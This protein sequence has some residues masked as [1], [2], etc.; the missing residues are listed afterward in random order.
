MATIH[1]VSSSSPDTSRRDKCIIK[2]ADIQLAV[3]T[4]IAELHSTKEED[5]KFAEICKY[6]GEYLY[7]YE[8]DIKECYVDDISYLYNIIISLLNEEVS[9]SPKY[10]KCIQKVASEIKEHIDPKN[11]ISNSHTDKSSEDKKILLEEKVN[12]ILE[13]SEKALEIKEL[14]DKALLEK[15]QKTDRE[16]DNVSKQNNLEQPENSIEPPELKA[17]VGEQPEITDSAVGTKGTQENDTRDESTSHH[18]ESTLKPSQESI[19]TEVISY[20]SSQKE[21][22]PGDLDDE[23]PSP[24][25]T[26]PTATEGKI[27]KEDPC[28]QQKSTREQETSSINALSVECSSSDANELPCADLST[29]AQK[30]HPEVDQLAKQS[31]EQL[32]GEHTSTSSVLSQDTNSEQH[33]KN[34]YILITKQNTADHTRINSN[35]ITIEELDVKGTTELGEDKDSSTPETQPWMNALKMYIIIGLAILGSLLLLIL[36]FKFTSLG[37]RFSNKKKKKRQEIQEE[38]ER[39]MYSPSNFNENNMYLSYAQLE[40]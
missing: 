9:K 17:R 34:T 26:L 29:E 3:N 19:L 24:A 27:L 22:P 4:K 39:M 13:T 12:K 11:E 15:S 1:V 33:S 5:A 38:L 40:D 31:Q 8:E 16:T 2:L 18:S 10:I 23:E 35:I 37:S 36:L 32:H 21:S 6:L 28:S 25:E 7:F 30:I 14:Q 20:S